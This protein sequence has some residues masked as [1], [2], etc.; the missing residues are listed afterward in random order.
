MKYDLHLHTNFSA[1]A[2]KNNSFEKLLTLAQ[3]EGL[4][5]ISITDHNTCIF[6]VINMFMDT[7]LFFKGK[8][9]SGMECDVVDSGITFELLAY[10]FDIMPI[11]KWSFDTYGTLEIR[12]NR[13][14]NK[15][16]KIIRKHGLKFDDSIVF[17]GKTDYAHK[18]V[19]ENLLK[20][21]ENKWLFKTYNIQSFNDF[22][23]LTTTANDFL[24]YINMSEFWPSVDKVID[25]IHKANGIVVLAHPF[26]YKTDAN[27]FLDIVLKKK[28]DGIEVYHQSANKKQIKFLLDFAK[29]NNLIITGG[30]DYHGTE[31]HNTIG[32]KNIDKN[33]KEISL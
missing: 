15:L 30:S 11:F 29:K 21:D 24:L 4:E 7:S 14:K 23:R 28:I 1:C 33:Q 31:K 26:N 25:A 9:I 8:I 6:H 22:Y 5:N 32:I 16:I 17:N 3:K 13:I 27:I 20:F 10:N 12:Q 18:Y 19:Y 2:N